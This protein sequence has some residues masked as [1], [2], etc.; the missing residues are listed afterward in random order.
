LSPLLSPPLNQTSLSEIGL[1]ARRSPS[2]EVSMMR[3]STFRRS[4]ASLA[5]LGLTGFLALHA[6]QPEAPG[7][8]TQSEDAD[9][10]KGQAVGALTY[11]ITIE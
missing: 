3:F 5:F 4:L 8:N 9:V 1:P 6:V 11:K 7:Q 2:R 10:P